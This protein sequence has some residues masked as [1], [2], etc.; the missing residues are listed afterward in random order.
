MVDLDPDRVLALSYVPAG[1]R[2]AVE[3]LWR[4]DVALGKVLAGGR[5][6][7]ISRIKLAWWREALEKLDSAGAPAEPLLQ[8]LA[9]HVVPLGVAGSELAAMEQGWA[10]LIGE[11]ELSEEDLA[12]YAR[13]RGANLF[14]LTAR[15]LGD[16][17]FD[18]EAAG[19]AWA[20]TDLARHSGNAPDREAA[21]AGAR[22]R[23]AP[24]RW[25]TRLRPLGML[26]I[27]ALRD[28]APGRPEWEATGS[29]GRMWRMLRHR[30]TGR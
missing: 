17:S 11:L 12:L 18:T 20:L 2:P 25:P 1:R 30:L 5:E 28:A 10:A 27:L 14:G 23:S 21:L 8:A 19:E 22:I 6:P 16:E 26:S 24:A 4:L 3:A 9:T 7:M 15:L 29:P 13:G